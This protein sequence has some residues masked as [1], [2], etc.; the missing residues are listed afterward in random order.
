MPYYEQWGHKKVDI[1]K[2]KGQNQSGQDQN[3]KKF[4]GTHQLCGKVGHKTEY[5]WLNLENA[6]LCPAW[7]HAN[8]SHDRKQQGRARV[9][10]KSNARTNNCGMEL[11]IGAIYDCWETNKEEHGELFLANF[12]WMELKGFYQQLKSFWSGSHINCCLQNILHINLHILFF[13]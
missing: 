8:A 9:D 5:C 12:E 10:G 3:K 4:S 2:Q 13:I 6:H 1:P 7:F 11:A